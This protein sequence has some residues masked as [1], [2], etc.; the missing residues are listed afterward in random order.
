MRRLRACAVTAA[1]V[2]P[3]IAP[4]AQAGPADVVK[5]EIVRTGE[6]Y[7]FDVTVKHD[8]TGPEHFVDR[9]EIV[10]GDGT[11]IGTR[12]LLQPHVNEQPFT[13]SLGGVRV[14]EGERTVR[15]R[16]HE[17]VIGFGGKE[18]TVPIPR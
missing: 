18:V 1:L 2:L 11:V 14:P 7:R 16:A 3:L 4:R 13:R 9:W 12:V 17:T 8:D 5:V 10:L 6:S 15:V